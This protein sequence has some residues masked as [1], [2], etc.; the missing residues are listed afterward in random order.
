MRW[1]MYEVIIE[2][3][4]GGRGWGRSAKGRERMRD[5]LDPEQAAQREPISMHR[6]GSKHLNE[7]LAPLRR[8]L[9]RR[10]GR[11]W[12]EVYA[13]ICA[14]LRPDS[15]VQKHVLDHLRD[16]VYTRV[17]EKDGALFE[18][19]RRGVRSLP[20]HYRRWAP[21]YVCPD[22]GV[23]KRVPAPP[24]VAPPKRLDVVP[25]DAGAQYRRI[26]G[27]WYRVTLSPVPETIGFDDPSYD[28]V[29]GRYLRNLGPSWSRSA[30]LHEQ[31]GR[32]DRYA[33]A[34]RQIG[35]RELRLLPLE[36]RG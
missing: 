5:R 29:L 35:K 24:K 17:V 31:Y 21:V 25:I 23:L 32:G 2:R 3:P 13:E 1:D 14:T 20:E 22:T 19:G 7:N 8:F 9:V 30:R 26:D 34:K 27:V 6:G 36:V 33:S 11:P 4:R 12:D 10:V 18:H 15:A 28:V 16:M